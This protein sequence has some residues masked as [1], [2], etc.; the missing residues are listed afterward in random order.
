MRRHSYTVWAALTSALVLASGCNPQQP[1][2]FHEDGSMSHYVGLATNISYPDVNTCSLGEVEHTRAPLTLDNTKFDETWDITLEEATKISLENAKIMRTLGGRIT[3][4]SSATL[5]ATTQITPATD[6][7]QTRPDAITTIYDP[8]IANSAVFG[9]EESALAAF[10]AQFS[11]SLTWNKTDRPQNVAGNPFA[12]T[13]LQQDVGTFATG[14]SK[15]N[16]TGGTASF[17]NNTTYTDSNAPFQAVNHDWYTDLTLGLRQPLLQGAGVTYNRIAGP[18]T[19]SGLSTG[20][21]QFNGVL[22]ARINTD[23]SLADFEAGVRN[24]VTDVENSYWELHFAYRNLE[25]RK[26]GRDAALGTW[27]TT[28]AKYCAGSKGGEAEKEFQAREQYH[29]FK[30]EVE[31]ALSD[32][33]KAENRLRYIMGLSATDGRLIRPKDEPTVAK[34]AF[35]WAQIHQEALSRSVD[36]RKQKWQIKRRELELVASKNLLLPR[37]DAVAQ[38]RFLGIGEDLI[39][40]QSGI[41]GIAGGN[42]WGQLADGNYQEWQLGFQFSMPLGFRKELSGVRNQ[43]LLLARERARLQDQELELSHQLTD[44]IRD[45]DTQYTLTQTNF[46]RLVSSQK[47]VEAV[48]AAYQAGAQDVTFDVLLNAQRRRSDAE[49][50]YYRS[51][52]DYNKSIANVHFHKGSLLEYNGVYLAEGPWPG[53]AYFDAQRRARQRDASTYMN[54]GYTNPEVISRGPVQQFGGDAAGMLPATIPGTEETLPPPSNG[55][56]R[57]M[58]GGMLPTPAMPDMQPQARM[59]RPAAPA[60]RVSPNYVDPNNGRATLVSHTSDIYPTTPNR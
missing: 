45:L 26:V 7:L 53:K 59:M 33:Y 31:S 5:A 17:T 24:L 40:N 19:P 8:A 55:K 22:L 13:V 41:P 4:N 23:V 2:Y 54:Y 6:A 28:H 37:L 46:N 60:G 43:Q 25:A 14:I 36:L 56:G 38:Y 30:A 27:R 51:L 12:P 58:N 21:P 34:V 9:G 10:D 35:D 20:Y 11:S 29:Q 57:P 32:L 18:Y 3:L 42:A 47:E 48:D 16:V 15:T 49:A 44:A 50:A 39:Q 1:F 52:I